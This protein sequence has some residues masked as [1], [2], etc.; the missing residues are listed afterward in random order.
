MKIKSLSLLS[1]LPP[2]HND[3]ICQ[4][5]APPPPPSPSGDDVI[6]D[7]EGIKKAHFT[8]R[9]TVTICEILYPFFRLEYDIFSCP[10]Q[11]NR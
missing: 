11:L 7:Y 4:L 2:C 10:K 8:V 9:L 6:Y 5:L 3:I 1:P